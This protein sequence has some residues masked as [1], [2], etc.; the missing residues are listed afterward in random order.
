M[1]RSLERQR[2]IRN[3]DLRTKLEYFS[4]DYDEE[5]EMKPRPEP[6]WE[7]TLTLR[8]RSH[9]VHRQLE[10]VMGFEEALNREGSRS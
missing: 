1:V 10:R 6:N 5:R 4:E 3:E 9:V 8:L 2:Q 7:A